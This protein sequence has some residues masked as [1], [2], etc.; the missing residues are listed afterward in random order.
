MEKPDAEFND[1]SVSTT[2][3]ITKS[4]VITGDNNSIT[5]IIQNYT[6][7]D[8]IVEPV[9]LRKQIEEYLIWVRERFAHIEL[10]GIQHEARQVIQLDLPA[11]YVPLEAIIQESR[12][13]I[14]LNEALGLG[15]RLIVTGGP[16]CGKTTVLQ[17]IAWTLSEAILT[18]NVA[19]AKTHLGYREETLQKIR[20]LSAALLEKSKQSYS[21][22]PANRRDGSQDLTDPIENFERDLLRLRQLVQARTNST[23]ALLYCVE[24]IYL[25]MSNIDSSIPDSS[26]KKRR[27]IEE[28]TTSFEQILALAQC[29]M[30]IMPLPIYVPLSTYARQRSLSANTLDPHERTLVTCISHY[31]I[32]KQSGISLPADF[33]TRLLQTGHSVILLLDGLDEVATESERIVVR[34]A[35][36]NLVRGR[37]IQVIVTCRTSAYKGRT[38]LSADFNRIIQVQPLSDEYRAALVRQA[39]YAVYP[40]EPELCKKRTEELLTGIS[41]LEREHQHRLGGSSPNLINSPLLVRMLLMMHLGARRLPEHRAELYTRITDTM[42]WPEHMLDEEVAE[43]IGR[44]VGGSLEAH[45]DLVQHIAFNMHKL[46]A[47][48]GR[49]LDEDELRHLLN[50]SPEFVSSINTFLTQTRLRGTLLE[51]RMGMYRFIHLAFQEFLAARYLAE[52]KRSEGG[53]NAIVAFFEEGPILTSWWREV[54]LLVVGYLSLTTLQTARLLLRRL[55]NLPNFATSV[56]TLPLEIVWTKSEIAATACREWM[57]KEDVLIPDLAH[58]IAYLFD[59]LSL[60]KDI[61]LT[62][63]S[64][65]ADALG[66][67]GDPRRGVGVL[68]LPDSD[69]TQPDIVWLSINA[70]KFI[71]GQGK[72]QGTSTLEYDYAISLYPITIA[73]YQLFIKDQGY[74]QEKYWTTTGWRWCQR[75]HISGPETYNDAQSTVI[76]N[77]PQVGVS[78]HEALAYTRW[79]SKRTGQMIRLPT[80]REWERVARHTDGRNYPWGDTYEFGCC[81]ANDTGFGRTT[82]VGIFPKGNAVCGAA[83]MSG[84]IGEWCSTKWPGDFNVYNP[85][86]HDAAESN[87]ERIVRGGSFRGFP[88]DVHS[89]SRYKA[90]PTLRSREIG[91]RLVRLSS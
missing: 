4:L 72:N 54:A 29:E 65:T 31:L 6:Q 43:H 22:L 40:Q 13:E 79:L 83:D 66:R 42:L 14:T 46:G 32:E 25:Q 12:R 21:L 30:E 76:S 81:N 18:N 67:L 39:Y 47:E 87:I 41:I 77:H 63:R 78:W 24:D 91:F 74:E 86:V 80:D 58:S 15:E 35:I 90:T 60:S 38:A 62:L 55:M 28:L 17:H 33:F 56:Q 19:L 8:L 34:A 1:R 88:F 26:T 50:S 10:R 20:Q 2:R 89:A 7:D 75:N 49:E 52:V 82:T 68:T 45:R 61:S 3:D 11:V 48:L 59:N 84:N 53:V 44:I 70:G 16:G 9:R 27:L 73:Q 51:E 36:E 85:Q 64:A 37:S 23:K 69:D 71:H 57:P 5:Q